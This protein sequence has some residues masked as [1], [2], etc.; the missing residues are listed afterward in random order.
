MKQLFPAA[1]FLMSLGLTACVG[2]PSQLHPGPDDYVIDAGK[3]AT[4]NQW[5]STKG[6]TVI[7]V[8]LPT[9]RK[10]KLDKLDEL[11]HGP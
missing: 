10:D 3:V 9:I 11:D 2:G 5:A 8:H 7:W 6:A 4:V 1:V